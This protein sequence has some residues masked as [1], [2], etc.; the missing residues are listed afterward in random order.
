QALHC[1]AA[2]RAHSPRHQHRPESSQLAG[3]QGSGMFEEGL[4]GEAEAGVLGWAG[5]TIFGRDGLQSVAV[6]P[7]AE[8]AASRRD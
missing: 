4:V 7:S 1:H 3:F 8:A 6:H 2:D 5:S